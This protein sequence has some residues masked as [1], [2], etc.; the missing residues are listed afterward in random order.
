MCKTVLT[1]GL[2]ILIGLGVVVTGGLGCSIIQK[3][4][5]PTIAEGPPPSLP[6]GDWG[7]LE[8]EVFQ[9]KAQGRQEIE[10][11]SI[12]C[13][14]DIGSLNTAMRRDTIVL[15][16]AI[17]KKT[18]ADTFDLRT[19]YK[20]R[21]V[22][23]L[24]QRP[25]PKYLSSTSWSAPPEE[26]KPLQEHEFVIEELNGVLE[27]DGVRVIQHSNSPVYSVGSTY[28][29]FL[30][31]ESS[32]RVAA[33]SGTDPLG[34]FTVDDSGTLSAYVTEQYPLRKQMET[35]FGNSITNLRSAL[36]N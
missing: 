31:L 2:V 36:K 28:L 14:S 3:K 1:A 10:I 7:T 30:H 4:V 27:I 24:S 20:F 19:W 5:E 29:L 16:E 33:R 34:V 35:R 12:L 8:R 25:V 6:E 32:R 18:Y 13:G 22:E 17:D 15:A 26:I 21:T 11:S 9:A 23:A